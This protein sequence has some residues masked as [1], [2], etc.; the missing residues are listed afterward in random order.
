MTYFWGSW[1]YWSTGW[2]GSSWHHKG[3]YSW[4][5]CKDDGDACKPVTKVLLKEDFSKDSGCWGW[6]DSRSDQVKWGDWINRWDA[7]VATGG[8]DGA[9]RTKAIDV[10][11]Q[12][13]L[14]VSFDAKSF[15]SSRHGDFEKT[16]PGA[17]SLTVRI[18][19]DG[20]TV[21]TAAFV[22][23]GNGTFRAVVDGETYSFT[24]GSYS[25]V[26]FDGIA[27][28]GASKAHVVFDAT[29]T[30]CDEFIKIDNLKV[31][32]TDLCDPP[33]PPPNE[34]PTAEN[35]AA[36]VCSDEE[37]QIAVSFADTDSASVDIVGILVG[38]TLQRFADLGGT[39][40]ADSGAEVT[41]NADGTLTYSLVGDDDFD[42]LPVGSKD[43]DSFVYVVEDSDG[44]RAEAT[45]T[46]DVCGAK[47]TL[48]TIEQSL[49]T[50]A[51]AVLSIGSAAT[52]F[53][54]T[55]SGTGDATFD[56]AYDIAYC[57]AAD[58]P[59][60]PGSAIQVNLEVLD[61]MV[62]AAVVSNPQ[63]MGYVNWI[64]N[65]DFT[66]I[67]NGDGVG[68]TYTEGE[69]QGAIWGFTDGFS[70]IDDVPNSF[71]TDQNSIEIYNAA[72]AAGAAAESFVPGEGDIVAV[73]LTTDTPNAI[74]PL[75]IGIEFD[76]L[77]VPCDC[78]CFA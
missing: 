26:T 76:T 47:N 65:Q 77:K 4:G 9:F 10:S 67:D 46:V 73:L 34:D 43:A 27:L 63:N 16:G 29:V 2:F 40:T 1:G 59:I 41:L 61:T 36:C 51:T 53:T 35:A 71:G 38:G 54:V 55:L 49:P 70:F 23:V 12:D 78:I 18:V 44:G 64:L 25:T 50:T 17:D 8:R 57:V 24:K 19:V 42:D 58:V 60:T 22:Y 48:E 20:E 3:W 28:D 21:L 5:G 32:G 30:A 11:G 68:Q 72:L 6:G 7:A 56:G 52:F 62:D 15:I 69:I 13:E 66:S 33:P 45:V 14:S 75:I 37:T 39:I 31:T 74:Q